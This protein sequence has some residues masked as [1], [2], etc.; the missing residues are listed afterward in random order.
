MSVDISEIEQQQLNDVSG[1][2]VNLTQSS[3]AHIDADRVELT[4]SA[5]RVI[6]ADAVEMNSS[7]AQMV[8]AETVRLSGSAMLGART[9]TLAVE[10]SV[11]CVPA[12][13]GPRS[14]RALQADI[15]CGLS[16]CAFEDAT[17]P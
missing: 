5:A 14:G 3:A 16:R 4:Q 12:N 17:K 9:E 8:E 15:A 7:A 13:R 1:Q 10:H 11:G 6:D 2:T